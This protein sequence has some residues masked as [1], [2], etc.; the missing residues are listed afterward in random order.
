[1]PIP[2][3]TRIALPSP[4]PGTER[5]LRVHR[6]GHSSARPKAYIQEPIHADEIPGLLV[7]QHLLR[8]LETLQAEGRVLGEVCLL[9]TSRFDPAMSSMDRSM[10]AQQI[11]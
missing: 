8:R 1:M 5:A 10:S 9:Y 4:A 2:S 7:A 6:Y 11:R 3:I